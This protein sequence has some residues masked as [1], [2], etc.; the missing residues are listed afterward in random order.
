MCQTYIGWQ[1]RVL[2]GMRDRSAGKGGTLP[3]KVTS[4][5]KYGP[6]TTEEVCRVNG[7]PEM[8]IQLMTDVG[9]SRGAAELCFDEVSAH[10]LV[11]GVTKKRL[12]AGAP[13]DH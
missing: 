4:P 13:R 10:G 12:L 5:S 6:W 1:G 7:L 9:A 8:I 2:R 11:E 3:C